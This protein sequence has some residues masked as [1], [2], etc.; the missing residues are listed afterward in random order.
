VSRG[1]PLRDADVPVGVRLDLESDAA[2]QEQ[3]RRLG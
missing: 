2:V 3:M 1:N